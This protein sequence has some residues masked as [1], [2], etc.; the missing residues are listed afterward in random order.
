MTHPATLDPRAPVVVV[1]G[2]AGSGKTTVGLVLAQRL[3]VTFADA[4]SFHSD[5]AKA[6][7]A[8]GHPL[9]DADR[10]PWLERLAAWLRDEPG[11]CVLACSALKRHYRDVLRSGAPQL[12]LLHLTADPALVTDRVAHR[13]GHYMPASLVASQY[14]ALEPLEPDENG[15][16]IAASADP[17]TIVTEFLQA[18]TA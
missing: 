13:L 3:G 10:A 1:M 11:G 14:Q 17:Q 12:V 15:V 2:V 7:M 8:A 5:E 4:D 6:L 18:V 16:V 9:T